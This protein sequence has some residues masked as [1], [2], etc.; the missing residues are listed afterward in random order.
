MARLEN[1][2]FLEKKVFRFSGFLG[3]NVRRPGTELWPRNSQRIFHTWY[4]L[5]PAA[6][7]V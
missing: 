4:I 2:G 1:L 5:S 3:F 7:R 6:S